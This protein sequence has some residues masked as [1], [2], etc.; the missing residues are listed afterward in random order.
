MLTSEIKGGSEDNGEGVRIDAKGETPVD[1]RGISRPCN[2]IP[3]IPGFSPAP[4]WDIIFS[5]TRNS[6]KNGYYTSSLFQAPIVRLTLAPAPLSL[7]LVL[8]AGHFNRFRGEEKH[9]L[10]GRNTLIYRCTAIHPRP[11]YNEGN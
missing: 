3:P 2:S 11:D 6:D 7:R 5:K 9:R 4:N 8:I 1:N 10:R